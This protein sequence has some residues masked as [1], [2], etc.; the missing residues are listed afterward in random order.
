MSFTVQVIAAEGYVA[1]FTNNDLC[2]DKPRSCL[3]VDRH[4]LWQRL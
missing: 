2:A 3:H 4:L 1:G